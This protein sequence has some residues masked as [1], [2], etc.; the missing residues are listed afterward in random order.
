MHHPALMGGKRC[1]HGLRISVGA[2]GG[3]GVSHERILAAC[4]LL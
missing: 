1:V 4:P 3:S 2:I